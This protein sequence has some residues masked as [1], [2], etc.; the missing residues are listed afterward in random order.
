MSMEWR[1][2][3]FDDLT[4]LELY[5]IIQLR[6]DVF[7]VEQNCVFQDADGVDKKCF[8]LSGYDGDTLAAYTRLIAPG[9]TYEY[10]S[11]GRV[12]SARAY[13]GKGIG[14]ELMQQSIAHCIELFG[15][16]PIKI[17][18]QLYLKNFYEEFG[19]EA[20]GE[21]YLEDNIPHIHML[22]MPRD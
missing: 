21:M 22:R 3:F 5:N 10:A 13:R 7:V 2:R 18:A 15:N 8:H 6:N 16:V 11:I 17:G 20:I 14:K 19:F 1:C 12:A 9:V 4:P